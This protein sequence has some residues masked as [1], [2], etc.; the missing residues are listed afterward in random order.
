VDR[1]TPQ[2]ATE[3]LRYWLGRPESAQ[4]RQLLPTKGKVFAK[5]GT[6]A[7]P[8]PLNNGRITLDQA[9]AGYLEVRPGRFYVFDLVV[10]SAVVLDI[11]GVIKVSGGLGDISAILQEDAAH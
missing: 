3:L 7:L 6:V 9:L 2:A 8:D 1:F 4:F 11:Q 5:G 10:N